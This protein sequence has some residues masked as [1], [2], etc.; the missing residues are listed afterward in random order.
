[1][2][3]LISWFAFLFL[4][5]LNSDISARD[6]PKPNENIVDVTQLLRSDKVRQLEIIYF[7]E[8]V[9][10]RTRL[11]SE[12]LEK[13]WRYKVVI[14]ELQSAPF[15]RRILAAAEA[16]TFKRTD[17]RSDLRLGCFFYD[18]Q[19]NRLLSFFS[20]ATGK[21][22][23]LNDELVVSNGRLAKVLKGVFAGFH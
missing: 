23:V 20:D 1:M 18:E 12:M 6:V 8:E 22:G 19:G 4:F 14:N 9:A 7:P 10:T 3:I 11:T 16:S 2:K 13:Q 15:K 5:S 17:V 21:V